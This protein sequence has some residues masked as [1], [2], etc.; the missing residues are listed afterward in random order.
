MA[1]GSSILRHT[2][3]GGRGSGRGA[4]PSTP[5][6]A[7]GGFYPAPAPHRALALPLRRRVPGPG[8]PA[9]W[10][11]LRVAQFNTAAEHGTWGSV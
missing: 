1:Q 2:K 9:R 11:F 3:G 4:A 8:S 10:D 6:D 5:S 7:A